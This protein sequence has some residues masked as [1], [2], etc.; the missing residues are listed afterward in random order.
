M[1]IKIGLDFDDV[2]FDF[3]T[4]M[5]KFHNDTY[6]TSYTL[7]D[8]TKWDFKELWQCDADES[9]RRMRAFVIS[10]YHDQASPIE[11]AI[12]AV[13]YLRQRYDIHIITARD[14]VIC[15]QTY[16]VADKFFSG[17]FQGVHYM[18]DNDKNVLGTKGDICRDLGIGIMVE[19]SLANAETLSASGITTLLFDRPWNQKDS[20]P[21]HVVRVFG[22]NDTL[23]KIK[24]FFH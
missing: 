21:T 12:D 2:L 23:A 5:M 6:G 4:G 24:D 18:H 14:K 22:W 3:N 8:I 20:L 19:D 10:K 11:G 7:A 15:P 13:R 9:L 17:S 1:R 16:K